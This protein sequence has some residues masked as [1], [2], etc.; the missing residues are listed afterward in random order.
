[1]I[2]IYHTHEDLESE[3]DRLDQKRAA[4]SKELSEVINDYF[5]QTEILLSDLEMEATTA[6]KKLLDRSY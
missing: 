6:I 3:V 5:L 4:L 2:K 1:M